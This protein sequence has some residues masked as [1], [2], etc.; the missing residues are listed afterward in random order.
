MGETILPSEF[1][2]PEI[3]SKNYFDAGEGEFFGKSISS[4]MEDFCREKIETNSIYG[5]FKFF[6][7]LLSAFG[8]GEIYFK[9]NDQVLQVGFKDFQTR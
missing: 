7:N 5:K 9:N 1:G 4:F 2:L 6:K 8:Y 3:F